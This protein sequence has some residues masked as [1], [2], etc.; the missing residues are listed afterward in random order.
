MSPTDPANSTY[1][2]IKTAL[3]N[4][5]KPK[6]ILIYECFKF[7]LRSQKP[8]ESVSDFIAAL[9]ELAHT[10]EFGTTLNDMLRDS[11]VIGWLM[12]KLSIPC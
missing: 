9:K 12:I 1:D 7:H 2:Q 11:F 3:K 6:V 4:H 5:Y 8:N 10:C